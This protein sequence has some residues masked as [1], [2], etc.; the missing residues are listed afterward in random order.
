VWRLAKRSEI[1]AIR[2]FCSEPREQ[3]GIEGDPHLVLGE[4][5]RVIAGD[6]FESVV[7]IA[8]IE[9]EEHS[10]YPVEQAAA[11]LQGFDCVGKAR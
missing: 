2:T 9:V 4:S 11:A 5:R 3:I 6:G 8:R 1:A 7:G 10:A